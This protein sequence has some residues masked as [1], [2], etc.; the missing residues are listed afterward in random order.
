MPRQRTW[1]SLPTAFLLIHRQ[2]ARIHAVSRNCRD[3][4]QWHCGVCCTQWYEH[5]YASFLF[6]VYF[7]SIIVGD[8]WLCYGMPIGLDNHSHIDLD[9]PQGKW[10]LGGLGFSFSG[11]ATPDMIG[12]DWAQSFENYLP[13]FNR[14][15]Q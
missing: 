3:D 11:A 5:Q 6:G 8:L 7:T 4:T 14:F 15:H 10:L 12:H 13:D 1:A 2:G 9:P